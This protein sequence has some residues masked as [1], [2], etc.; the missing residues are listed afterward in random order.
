MKNL[1]LIINPIAGMGGKV[2]LKGTD[3]EETLQRARS[4]G[5]TPESPRRAAEALQALAGR[6]E[7][8]RFVTAPESM[9]EEVL[10][11]LGRAPEVLDMEVGSRT[12]ARHTMYAAARMR[13]RGVDL[14]LFAGGDGTAR[15]ILAQVQD[16]VVCLGIPTGVK[17]HSAVFAVNPS[18]AGELAG[19]Y[20]FEE[21]LRT[22]A[23][24]VMDID[25]T[26]LREGHV[27]A[28]LFGYLTIPY[29]RGHVQGLKAGSTEEETT[30]QKAIAA[31]IVENMDAGTTYIIGP[32]TTTA[33]IMK[34]LMLDFSL[35]GVDLVR[36]G[37]LLGRDLS[38][39]DLLALL[40]EEPASI[41]VTPVGGQGYLFG[42]GNQPI[43]ARVIRKVGRDR[44]MIVATPNKLSSLRGEPL[45]VD[46]GDA[47]TD[48]WL[49]GYYRVV[50]G[51]RDR[52]VYRI[53]EG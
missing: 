53:A 19:Q 9:G 5:A 33:E 7:D 29:R 42:R 38:E 23:A 35:V 8:L 37:T 17:M 32:G 28:R 49:A 16:Q 50:S 52:S 27:H 20:L 1:G 45:R 22:R 41:I 14:L 24:E 12:A 47:V 44:I 13:D 11:G 40:G 30:I 18:R 26:A 51:Y 10:M 39:T 25:E 3:G 4:L 21:P 6:S 48:R 36:D 43:S 46:S 34:L 31:G 15:D 2:G